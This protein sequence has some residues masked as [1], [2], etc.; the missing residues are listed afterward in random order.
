MPSSL[1]SRWQ[2]SYWRHAAPALA[3]VIVAC[4][5]LSPV[6][7]EEQSLVPQ[8]AIPGGPYTPGTSYYGSNSYIEYIA[9]NLPVIFAAPHGGSLTPSSIPDRTASNCGGSATTVTDTNTQELARAIR[10]AFYNRTGKYPHVIIN[11]LHRRKLDANRDLLEAACGNAAAATAWHD[12]HDFIGVAKNRVLTDYGRGWF[13]DVHGHGHEIQR[14]ELGYRLS[15]S[16]LR[17]SDATLDGSTTYE[18]KSSFRTFSQLSPLSFSAVLRGTTALGTLF[19][20][21]GYPSV[22]SAQDP[23]PASG[24]P[25]FNGGYNTDVHG[26]N[27]GGNI[28]GV[29]IE[30][31]YTGVRDNADNRAAYAA[32]LAEVYDVFLAQNFG[33]SL[34]STR[35]EV[36]V[37]NNNANNDTTRA[38]FSASTNW[39]TTTNNTK[40]YL[41][42]FRLT[43]GAGPTNDGASFLFRVTATGSYSV[44]AWWPSATTRSTTVSYR[45]FETD[46]GTMLADLKV[47]QQTNGGQWNHLGTWNFTKTGWGK[48]LM[49]RSLSGAGTMAADGIRVVRN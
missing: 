39:S 21:S 23:A 35:G 30:H 1:R 32:A 44:Y 25:Y 40:K 31:H 15:G 8:F 6:S 49:S 48:V 16:E 11:R 12:F 24:E 38:K 33:L 17:L 37:D 13:T 41:N 46:G 27:S 5:E 20:T 36:V 34:A 45:V 29:Q 28:C 4:T 42:N 18:N 14:L 9:G 10:T 22:P 47:N 3:L 7:V 2:H 43:D 26:C 19:A